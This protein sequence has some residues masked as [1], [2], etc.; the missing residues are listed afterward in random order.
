MNGTGFSSGC[1]MHGGPGDVASMKAVIDWLNGRVPGDDE[2]G[3]AVTAGWHNGKAAMIGKSYD[4][5]LANAVAATGVEGLTTIVPISAI[6]QW[7]EYSRTGGIRHNTGYPSFLARAVTNENRRPLCAPSRTWLDSSDGDEHGDIHQFW[8]DRDHLKDAGNVEASVFIT[9]GF[10]D[11][12]VRFNH[13]TTWWDALEQRKVPRKM[14]L[15]RTGH[16]DPFDFRRAAWVDT[17][18]RWFDHWLQGIDNGIMDEPRVDVEVAKDRWETAPDWPI[19]G[20][21]EIDVY[22]QGTAPGSA[23]ALGLSSGGRPTR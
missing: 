2:D 10:Q 22:L 12:N 16:K 1:P 6:S 13:A 11:D 8:L 3:N 20:T 18:H 5:T 15:T 4:G 17:L 14:W 23:G 19:P 7:Y 9:H 21:H